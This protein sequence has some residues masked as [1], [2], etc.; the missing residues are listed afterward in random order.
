M[1]QGSHAV[2]K[3]TT[4]WFQLSTNL[5]NRCRQGIQHDLLPSRPFMIN[6]PSDGRCNGLGFITTLISKPTLKSKLLIFDA[7]DKIT[8][9]N[10]PGVESSRRWEGTAWPNESRRVVG[11]KALMV[12]GNLSASFRAGRESKPS[13]PC[14]AMA[15]IADKSASSS[16]VLSSS[17]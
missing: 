14:E 17:V 4:F 8:E 16:T 6:D 2:F 12:F 1:V 10:Q 5:S 3:L 13:D 9:S 15:R 11:T 7:F